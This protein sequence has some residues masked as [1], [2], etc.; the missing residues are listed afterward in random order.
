[1]NQSL[2]S[3]RRWASSGKVSPSLRIMIFFQR[4]HSVIFPASLA[5]Q[6]VAQ[7]VAFGLPGLVI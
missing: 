2:K 7:A 1:M 3:P 4:W 5:W 6:T